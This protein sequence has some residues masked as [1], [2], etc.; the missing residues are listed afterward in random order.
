[1]NGFENSSSK[2]EMRGNESETAK[3]GRKPQ[4]PGL[5]R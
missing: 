1:M 5:Y 3:S 2:P 4:I